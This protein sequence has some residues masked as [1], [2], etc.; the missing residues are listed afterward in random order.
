MVDELNL[1]IDEAF[2]P[3]AQSVFHHLLATVDWDKRRRARKTA[4]FGEPYNY[5]GIFYPF[6]PMPE[7]LLPLIDKIEIRFGYRPNNCLAN[8]YESGESTMGFHSDAIEE[9]ALD[10]GI[11]IVSLGAERII[12]FQNKQDKSILRE[13][14]LRNG[15]LLLMSQAV[16]KYWSH[17]ILRQ[18]QVKSARISLTFR[19][20]VN[21]RFPY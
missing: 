9:L 2:V 17:A 12:H 7:N 19:L 13:F 6:Q 3:D 18:E 14:T 1:T 21:Q 4:S 11:I 15:S 10:T 16:Q 5:S 20:F 8:Y